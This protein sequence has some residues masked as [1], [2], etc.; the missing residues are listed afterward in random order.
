LEDN[1]DDHGKYDRKRSDLSGHSASVSHYVDK[2]QRLG[3][4]VRKDLCFG[5]V[6]VLA[7][8]ETVVSDEYAKA[9]SLRLALSQDTD[10]PGAV[11]EV[12]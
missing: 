1:A 11:A 5:R 9:R 3:A 4:G 8:A 12:S 7:S 6:R 2:D 10:F